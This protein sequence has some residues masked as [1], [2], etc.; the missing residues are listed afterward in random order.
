MERAEAVIPALKVEVALT[1]RVWA[2]DCPKMVLPLKVAAPPAMR[3]EV[4][5]VP[6]TYKFVVVAS[7]VVERVA[8][9][10]PDT[11]RRSVGA[12]VPIPILEFSPSIDNIGVPVMMVASEYELIEAGMVVVEDEAIANVLIPE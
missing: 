10:P 1:V 8:E 12:T 6:D 2:A 9:N 11:V 4:E 5:A 7:V 3:P